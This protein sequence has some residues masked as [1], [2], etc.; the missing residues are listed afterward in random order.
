M[1]SH[2]VPVHKRNWF[3]PVLAAIGIALVVTAIILGIL[4][5]TGVIGSS[6]SSQQSSQPPSTSMSVSVISTST[7][8]SSSTPVST[9]SATVSVGSFAYAP[10]AF[11]PSQGLWPGGSVNCVVF[12]GLL[13]SLVCCGRHKLISQGTDKAQTIAV[14]GRIHVVVRLVYVYLVV[15]SCICESSGA[16]RFGGAAAVRGSYHTRLES[17]IVRC[18]YPSHTW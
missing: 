10:V 16:T 18:S 6:S 13:V 14:H 1:H 2:G 17:S 12:N 15:S 9:T 5:G 3:W 8:V 7:T 4:A 11:E